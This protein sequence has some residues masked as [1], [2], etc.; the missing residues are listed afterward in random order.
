MPDDRQTGRMVVA[1]NPRLTLAFAAL[2]FEPR[3]CADGPEL[4]E[5]LH[6]L[7]AR[8]DV[9]LVVVGESQAVEAGKAVN[10][11]RG[12]SEAILLLLPD[13]SEARHL[14]ARSVQ[15]EIE[16]ATGVDLLGNAMNEG[17]S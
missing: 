3:L 1:G 16:T 4:A 15:R 2:G 10:E 13:T 17:K 12:N 5:T 6:K 9:F 7:M 14:D 11:F 8:R